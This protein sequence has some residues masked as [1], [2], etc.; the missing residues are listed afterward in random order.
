M[1]VWR[2]YINCE[3]APPII[4]MQLESDVLEV[5]F[6]W[7]R[8]PLRVTSLL[9]LVLVVIGYAKPVAAAADTVL[10]VQV[11]ASVDDVNEV[12]NS[13]DTT[14]TTQWLGN[15]GA[16][17]GSYA[18]MRFTG[19][20][21]PQGSIITSAYLQVFSTQDQW[22]SC[23]FSI[24][25]DGVG[26]SGPFTS[27]TPLSQRSLTVNV[28]SHRDDVSWAANTWYSL[29][30]M[31]A[32]VQEVVGRTDWQS[33]NSLSIILRGTGSGAFS[34][35]FVSSFDEAAANAPR[36]V[37]T[38]TNSG[39]PVPSTTL[40]T[41]PTTTAAG[42]SAAASTLTSQIATSAD[43]VNEVDGTLTTNSW[44]GNGGS[45]TTSYT[46]FR[47]V[48]LPFLPARRSHPLTFRSTR[49]RPN[50]STTRST[51]RLSRPVTARCSP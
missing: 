32:V 38:Y 33:G 26:N 19:V 42:Q 1:N 17:T 12:N 34:R 21:I 40:T 45:T 22:I 7:H 35:K 47:F 16:T 28:V 41:A 27:S 48:N 3:T 8:A 30:D 10:T 24:A 23:A 14:S 20:L 15:G 13:L 2:W 46:G 51:S 9:V 44:L 37:V 5:S 25:A 49:R 6:D 4:H 29:D 11:G 18:G 39:A 36:L 43:D 50:G 31:K